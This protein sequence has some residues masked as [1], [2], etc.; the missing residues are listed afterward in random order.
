MR[1]D[2]AHLFIARHQQEGW[3]AAIAL[4]AGDEE[5]GLGMGELAPA[6]RRHRSAGM[7]IGIDQRA[8]RAAALDDWIEIELNFARESE[9]RA[10][11]GRRDDTVERTDGA[12]ALRCQAIHQ[13][14]IAVHP[15]ALGGEAHFD[16]EPF[17]LDE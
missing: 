2:R 15:E 17:F 10:L 14:A 13:D 3:C 6:M 11:A 9:I 16:R 7:D 4:D 12:D 8:E 1:R 5:I